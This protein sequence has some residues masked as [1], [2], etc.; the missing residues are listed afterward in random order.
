MCLH[1]EAYRPG[2]NRLIPGRFL[3]S[4]IMSMTQHSHKNQLYEALGQIVVSFNLLERGIDGLIL[5]CMESMPA[6]GR[7]LL[8]NMPFP[9]KVSAMDELIRNSHSEQELGLLHYTLGALVERVLTCRQQRDDWMQ[10][11][12]VPEIEHA[13]GVVMRL[14]RS[15]DEI[16]LVLKPVNIVQLENFIVLLNATIAYL[17]GFHQKLANNFKRIQDVQAAGLF[18]KAPRPVLD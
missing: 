16:E 10:S 6:H 17:C 1:A 2:H 14:Q 15:V 12:W 9:Q 18:L 4:G 3:T 7:I 11:Y 8:T 13:P 5:A